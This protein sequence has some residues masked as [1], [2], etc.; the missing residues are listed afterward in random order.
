L[1]C[2]RIFACKNYVVF[3]G[4]MILL[5]AG[6]LGWIA[7]ARLEAFHQHHLDIGHESIGGVNKQVAHYVNE[8]QRMVKLFA[9][10]HID[11][12]RALASDPNNDA[13]KEDLGKLLTRYFPDRFAF[14]I[15]DNSGEPL[16]EDFDGLVSQLCLSDVKQFSKDRHA[17]HPYIHP[18]PEGYHFDIMVRYDEGNN[19]EGIFFVSFLADV[20][21]NIINSIQSPNHQVMLILPQRN[22][23]IEV[24][25]EGAR[26]HWARDDYRLSEEELT[27]ISMRHDVPGTRWQVIEFHN[28]ELHKNYRNKLI[29]ESIGIFLIFIFIALQL[30]FRLRK[31]ER[32]R[33]IAQEQKKALMGVISHEFRSP[34]SAITCALD[35]IADSSAGEANPDVKKYIDLASGSAS[36]LLLL[37]DD[38][39]EIQ[40]I[41]SGS[42]EFDIQESQLSSVVADVV[43]QN[44]LYAEQFS[45]HYKLKEPLANDHVSCD[46]NRIGQVLTNLLSNAAKYGGENDT[47]EVAVTRVGKR[48]RVSIRDHGPGISENFQSRVFEA[49]AMAH[50]PK[51]ELTN[52]QKIKSSGLGLSIAKAIIEHHGGSIGFDT[53]TEPQSETGTTFWFEL[54]VV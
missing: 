54:P 23:L 39:L 27:R 25:A 15:T 51:K 29:L 53:K 46:E 19:R 50:A 14:S 2:S 24:I 8:K 1:D 16:F 6:A 30:V 22:N 33:E 38:F 31:E 7:S 12:I 41:E 11:R 28:P 17:Y 52:D 42:L 18:N 37:V 20:L 9:E 36:R 48:L 26:N 13:L 5:V 10:E 43:E 32:Q 45:A 21:G 40:K 3:V 49:F 35:L 4:V 47:I 44:K 34:A